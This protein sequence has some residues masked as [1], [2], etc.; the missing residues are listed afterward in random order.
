LLRHDALRKGIRLTT[1]GFAAWDD[2]AKLPQFRGVSFPQIQRL[3]K[4][5][6]KQ[7]FKV[8]VDSTTGKQWI[9]C[10]Q[11]HSLPAGV[12]AADQLLTPI[13]L[14]MASTSYPFVVHG[15]DPAAWTLIKK[16]GGLNRMKRH[17]IHMAIG[18]PHS[19]TVISGMRTTA[20]ITIELDVLQALKAGI[21][22]FV[23][24]NGVVLS[25]GEGATGCIPARFFKEVVD[26]QTGKVLVV[27][28]SGAAHAPAGAGAGA[29]A[30]AGAYGP[31]R[32]PPQTQ[33]HHHHCQR[34]QPQQH[35]SPQLSGGW[36]DDEAPDDGQPPMAHHLFASTYGG[37][38]GSAG[39]V[40][41]S[42]G[43][44]AVSVGAGTA[45]AAACVV[46]GTWE[47]GADEVDS[48]DAFMIGVTKEAAN[49]RKK[50]AKRHR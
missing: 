34:Q 20:A 28:R 5:C 6:K 24:S 48:L 45:A 10:N 42:A 13:T 29:G 27:A 33:S 19:G 25:P 2:V 14:E 26:R 50:D 21:P 49:T 35:H 12:I 4:Q 37:A 11:G 43:T 30:P 40:D 22:F 44:G 15:T 9:R 32:P 41:T 31:P 23:S 3:V 36:Y 1:A 38:G 16:S 47:D 7:R 18:L 17:H 46:G 8:Q 39:Y